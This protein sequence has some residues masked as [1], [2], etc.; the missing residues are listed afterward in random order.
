MNNAIFIGGKK[1]F[2]QDSGVY[3]YYSVY[4]ISVVQ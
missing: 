1:Q 4:Q 3:R 2:N